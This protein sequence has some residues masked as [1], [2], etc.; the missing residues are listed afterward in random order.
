MVQ[1]ENLDIRTITMNVPL[2][3]GGRNQ[4]TVGGVPAWD[5]LE[6]SVLAGIRAPKSPAMPFDG[7]GRIVA[8]QRD[9]CR[10]LT[11]LRRS[12]RRTPQ[13]RI[14]RVEVPRV[15]REG[16]HRSE[17][18]R[19]PFDLLS[20]PV[21]DAILEKA[22]NFLV[23]IGVLTMQRDCRHNHSGM[24]DL[25]LHVQCS[26]LLSKV[27]FEGEVLFAHR[28]FSLGLQGKPVCGRRRCPEF[29]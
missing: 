26:K 9:R 7:D 4:V 10:Q 18:I 15:G 5:A 25:D 29:E 1:V 24:R 3:S 27:P 6:V 11:A 21:R 23:A 12:S 20:E 8:I 13:S 28:H 2:A 17:E 16:L 14:P 19:G 22:G